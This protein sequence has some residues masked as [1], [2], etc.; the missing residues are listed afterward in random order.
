MSVIALIVALESELSRR[1]LPAGVTV[2]HSGV[3]KVNAAIATVNT[4]LNDRPALVINYGT[5]GRIRQGLAGLVEVAR[6][7]QR[8]MLAM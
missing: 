6:V 5:A 7:I 2:R 4:I 1:T 8:D 3:G